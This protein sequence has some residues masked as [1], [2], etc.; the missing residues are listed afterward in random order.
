LFTV[1]IWHDGP[2]T[3]NPIGSTPGMWAL[4]WVLQVMPLFFFVG[5]FAHLVTWES[6]E[7]DGGDYREFLRRRLSRL[8]RPTVVCL[9]LI[10]AVRAVLSVVAPGVTWAT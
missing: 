8:L 10:L 2:H 4:T 7:R 3:S 1:V 9:A 6:V 5:G